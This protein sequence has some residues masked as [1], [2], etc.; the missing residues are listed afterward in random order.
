MQRP[1]ETNDTLD[2]SRIVLLLPVLSALT[3]ALMQL[4]TRQLG[5]VARASALAFYIQLIFIF[6]SLGF[7]II[8]G[9]GRFAEGVQSAS[10]QFLFRAWVAPVGND[11]WPLL[12]LGLNS[13]VI[14][15]CLSQAY[16][17]SDAATVAPFEYIGLPLAV[18]WGWVIWADV[19]ALPI[20][21]G[22]G[23]IAASGLFVFVRER[24]MERKIA[25]AAQV[26]ARY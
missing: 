21:I 4:M 18:M 8:A 20:W 22:I 11:W 1:W 19:P 24:Q 3:Y 26:K 14:G 23:L 7:G 2:Y 15:Y 6:V 17:L 25:R 16:R 5:A 12:G 9:D 13:A 10:L